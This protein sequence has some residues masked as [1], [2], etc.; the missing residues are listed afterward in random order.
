M[1]G[2]REGKKRTVI[3][4]ALTWWRTSA[5]PEGKPIEINHQ[6]SITTNTQRHCHQRQHLATGTR[7]PPQSQS[8]SSP[9]NNHQSFAVFSQPQY[10]VI[11]ILQSGTLQ[12]AVIH[13]AQSQISWQVLQSSLISATSSYLHPATGR[14]A[15]LFSLKISGFIGII[16]FSSFCK[17]GCTIF[18][19]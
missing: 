3:S 13:N 10:L 7:S 14:A 12:S 1:G 18:V 5:D 17:G 8:P 6:P 15:L 11:H 9:V 19:G 2:G 16:N 4:R